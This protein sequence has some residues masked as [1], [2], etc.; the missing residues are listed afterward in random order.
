M[1]YQKGQSL[2]QFGFNGQ[3]TDT[4]WNGG[5]NEAFEFRMNDPRLGRFLSF[6]P[7]AASTPWNSPYLFANNSPIAQIDWLGLTGKCPD[8]G[9]ENPGEDGVNMD[10]SAS[11]FLTEGQ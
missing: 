1:G 9:D 6:D 4:E 3:I 8:C 10:K 2:Y 7:L 5:Q 11:D